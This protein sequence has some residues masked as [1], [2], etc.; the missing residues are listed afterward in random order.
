MP[1]DIQRLEMWNIWRSELTLH[2]AYSYIQSVLSFSERSKWIEGRILCPDSI[3]M[4]M[5]FIECRVTD[6]RN[7]SSLIREDKDDTKTEKHFNASWDHQP[8]RIFLSPPR[9]SR[10]CVGQ[11]CQSLQNVDS[12]RIGVSFS[13]SSSLVPDLLALHST[14][15]QL[16]LSQRDGWNWVSLQWRRSLPQVWPLKNL[17]GFWIFKYHF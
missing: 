11:T 5:S 3:Q 12:I 6:L 9:T 7:W 8:W 4:M 16:V 17:G 14:A 10:R 1:F 13:A 15:E 2:L